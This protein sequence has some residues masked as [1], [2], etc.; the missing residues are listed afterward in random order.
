MSL[1]YNVTG[2]ER[3]AL[4]KA[5]SEILILDAVYKGAPTFA[6]EIGNCVVDRYGVLSFS[7]EV[8][9]TAAMMLINALKTRGFEAEPSEDASVD[10]NKL[11]IQ[12]PREGFTEEALDNLR[13]IIASKDTLI[14]KALGLNDLPFN[15]NCLA[16]KVDEDKLRFPW[17]ALAGIDGE[18]DAYTRF[19][20]ALCEMAKTQKR[21]TA[22]ER[23][24]ENDKL[25]MRLFL[26]RLGFIGAGYKTARK[27]LLRNLIG[28]SSWKHGRPETTI[29][30]EG[31]AA[32]GDAVADQMPSDG[33][34]ET[35]ADAQ[36]IHEVNGLFEQQK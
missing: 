8:T 12:I 34:A 32:I 10:S 14:K 22:K 35:L 5:I 28:N 27:I 11:E 13:K 4:V 24:V 18:A 33:L 6:Y 20:H 7:E 36:L 29:V 19:I 23:E 15:E 17:F 31:A 30:A 1:N 26:I 21:V 25:A 9:D 3:K 2:D 16:V